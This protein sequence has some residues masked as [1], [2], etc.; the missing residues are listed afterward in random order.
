MSTEV[1]TGTPVS[2]ITGAV[3]AAPSLTNV[4]PTYPPATPGIF[5]PENLARH[6]AD[7]FTGVPKDHTSALVGYWT[8]E[9][10]W[11]MTVAHRIG[12]AWQ[13]GATF[14][15]DSEAGGISGGVSIRGSW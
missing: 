8:T 13:M 3:N 1:K 9:G 12:D 15:K 14:G 10:A 7:A 2:S 5:A 4:T 11:R 6:I